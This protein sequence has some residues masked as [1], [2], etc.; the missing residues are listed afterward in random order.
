MAQDHAKQ[1]STLKEKYEQL[2]EWM[3]LNTRH[4]DF[5]K[6]VSERNDLSVQME[7][8]RQQRNGTWKQMGIADTIVIYQPIN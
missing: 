6:V 3:K 1:L 2:T 5:S 7:V 8:V 4:K